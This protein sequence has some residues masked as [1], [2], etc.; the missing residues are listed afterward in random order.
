MQTTGQT[1]TTPPKLLFF[2]TNIPKRMIFS[3]NCLLN[4][5]PREVIF[6]IAAAVVEEIWPDSNLYE[7]FRRIRELLENKGVFV[8]SFPV[9]YPGIDLE[10][11][12]DA[13]DYFWFT[14]FHELAHLILHLNDEMKYFFDDLKSYKNLSK[15]EKEADIFAEEKLIAKQDWESFIRNI[16]LKMI[17]IILLKNAGYLLQL[18]QGEYRKKEM[19]TRCL[20]I[21]LVRR[22]LRSCFFNYSL[23]CNNNSL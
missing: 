4:I 16:F 18:Q 1:A 8:V 7:S 11:N 6:W 23:I 21:F 5:F 3:G 22:K 15:I 9:N 10:T 17:F 20:E 13:V 12:R 2:Q 14:L 19:I